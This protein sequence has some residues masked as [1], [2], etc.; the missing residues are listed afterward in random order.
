[1]RKLPSYQYHHPPHHLPTLTTTISHFRNALRNLHIKNSFQTKSNPHFSYHTE[2]HIPPATSL[3]TFTLTY[4]Y[5]HIYL[6]SHIFTLTYI[7]T[8]IHLHSHTFTFILIAKFHSEL[9][10][11]QLIIQI[12]LHSI[13]SRNISQFL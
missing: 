9:A 8:H 4:I 7:Y 5:T 11:Y 6:H 13:F 3:Y 12:N 10:S 1:M 2:S